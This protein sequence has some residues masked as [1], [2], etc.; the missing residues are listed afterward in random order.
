[1]T[2]HSV[3]QISAVAVLVTIVGY[4][5]VSLISEQPLGAQQPKNGVVE[6]KTIRFVDDQGATSATLSVR[7]AR[8]AGKLTPQ[9][10]L[11]DAEGKEVWAGPQEARAIPLGQ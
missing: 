10:V 5:L 8:I 11:L 1:M 4:V 3:L 2:K 6:L 7:E 9:L